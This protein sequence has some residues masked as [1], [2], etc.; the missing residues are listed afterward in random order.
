MT[1]TFCQAIRPLHTG[2][3]VHRQQTLQLP[4]HLESVPNSDHSFSKPTPDQISTE[5]TN[6]KT[7][8]FSDTVDFLPCTEPLHIPTVLVGSETVKTKSPSK[9]KN[10]IT[11]DKW[12]H[13]AKVPA[14]C[15]YLHYGSFIIRGTRATTS[16]CLPHSTQSTA[17]SL[18]F[19]SV[20]LHAGHC[21]RLAS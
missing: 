2:T 4:G 11:E 16:Y 8:G 10:V 19:N 7:I 12:N 9:C 15:G 14:L 1:Q 17:L 20:D 13:F 21:S 5:A 3:K 18:N 6:M